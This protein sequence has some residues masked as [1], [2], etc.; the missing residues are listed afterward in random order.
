MVSR[1]AMRERSAVF[2]Q[3]A[4]GGDRVPAADRDGV[5]NARLRNECLPNRCSCPSVRAVNRWNLLSVQPLGDLLQRH[6]LPEQRVDLHPP[7]VV[8]SVAEPVRKPDVVGREVT[9]VRLESRI[10]VGSRLPIGPRRSRLEVA[11]TPKAVALG[12]LAAHVDD[13]AIPGELPEDSANSQALEPLNW[14]F[15]SVPRCRR[16][17]SLRDLLLVIHARLSVLEGGDNRAMVAEGIQRRRPEQGFR[18]GEPE[19]CSVPPV[20]WCVAMTRRHTRQARHVREG[21][22]PDMRTNDSQHGSGPHTRRAGFSA[23]CR[24]P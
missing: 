7:C 10:V 14:S 19:G 1:E 13:L 3:S 23:L 5:R 9:S 22:F 4:P 15:L 12:H 6:A 21:T 18:R 16:G 2:R 20:R 11:T 17:S 8:T 24:A